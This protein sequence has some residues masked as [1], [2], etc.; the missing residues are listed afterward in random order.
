MSNTAASPHPAPAAILSG[1]NTK[2]VDDVPSEHNISEEAPWADHADSDQDDLV[3][4]DADSAI[5]EDKA[6]STASITSSILRY[7]TIRGRTYHSERVDA[8]YWGANNQ[9]QNDAMDVVHHMWTLAQN[10]KLFQAPIS[11]DIQSQLHC[12]HL[13]T[14]ST[15]RWLWNWYV[16][17]LPMCRE[18]TGIWAIDFADEFPGFEVT[19][20]DISPIQ[21]SFVPPN[22]KFEIDDCTL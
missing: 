8:F 19:G 17:V 14:D 9:S 20:T 13:H 18:S 6:D 21:P 12:L 10:G 15:R 11:D 3:S 5:G 1:S 22:L 2:I 7:R 4:N 16:D